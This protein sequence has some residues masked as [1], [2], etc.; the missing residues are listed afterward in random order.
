MIYEKFLCQ[1]VPPPPA[2]AL[3]PLPE[4]Q[5]EAQ[6]T[7]QRVEQVHAK[8]PVCAGC[9]KFFD[10]IGFGLEA[11]D[12]VGRFRTEENGVPVD[13]S[14]ELVLKGEDGGKVVLADFLDEEGLSAALAAEPHVKSCVAGYLANYAFGGAGECLADVSAVD[15]LCNGEL[16][17]DGFFARLAA[18]PHFSRRTP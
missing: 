9:H 1:E 16:G 10:P 4:A 6:T 5:G 8:D 2:A 7:R 17:L 11:F 14:G 15:A 3:P 12:E 13:T 18:S